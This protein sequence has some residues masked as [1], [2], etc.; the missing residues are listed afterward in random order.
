[1]LIH[2]DRLPGMHYTIHL[3]LSQLLT[4]T[5]VAEYVRWKSERHCPAVR[6]SVARQRS[7]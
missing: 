1:M 5:N 7:C 6:G 4:G 2:E 3:V